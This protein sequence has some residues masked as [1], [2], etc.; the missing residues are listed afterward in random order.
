MV[1]PSVTVSAI[2]IASLRS[3]KLLW[4]PV[5][6]AAEPPNVTE[7]AWWADSTKDSPVY[8]SKKNFGGSPKNIYYYKIQDK[9]NNESF[10]NRSIKKIFSFPDKIS[11]LSLE[12]SPFLIKKL[13][14]EFKLR[15][16]RII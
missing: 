1:G 4:S 12:Y 2:E 11:K 13:Y 16:G 8:K 3:W 6:V 10:N 5:S 15:N 7:W 9:F 14:A